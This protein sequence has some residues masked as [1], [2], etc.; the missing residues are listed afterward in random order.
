MRNGNAFFHAIAAALAGSSF[1]LSIPAAASAPIGTAEPTH[2]LVRSAA[3][4]PAD[5]GAAR[6]RDHS[7]LVESEA[8]TVRRAAAA[9]GDSRTAAAALE[10]AWIYDA[11]VELFD[12]YDGD[13][14][15]TYIRVSFDADSIYAN[16]Y[17]YA[18]LF[19]TLDGVNWDEYHVTEDILIEGSSP[20]DDYEVETELVT[21]FPS[22]YY[23]ALIELYDADFGHYLGEFGPAESSAFSLLPL[24]DI[25]RDVVEPVVVISNEGGGGAVDP[26]SLLTLGL[27]A[28]CAGVARRRMRQRPNTACALV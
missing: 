8:L 21:G 22:G 16:H 5:R 17:V 13:G 24:E 23:D 7:Q 12:D 10:E 9:K 20:F 15:Y 6:T 27:I 19:L 2:K 11:D 25:D 3:G 1:L 28:A 18:R 4:R 26:Y 14:Y